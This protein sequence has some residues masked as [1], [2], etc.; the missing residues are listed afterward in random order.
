[1]LAWWTRAQENR[2]RSLTPSRHTC[3]PAGAEAQPPR[4]QT[5][6]PAA[7]PQALTLPRGSWTGQSVSNQPSAGL[8]TALHADHHLGAGQVKPSW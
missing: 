5:R 6:H 1:M 2:G 7:K 3:L 8:P 4:A